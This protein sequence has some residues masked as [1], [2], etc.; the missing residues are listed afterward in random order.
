[1]SSA[2]VNAATISEASGVE[3]PSALCN[4][5]ACRGSS[6]DAVPSAPSARWAHPR[7]S[8]SNDKRTHSGTAAAVSATP[9]DASP[10]G[11]NAQS[12]AARKLSISWA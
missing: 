12:S 5:I 6:V 1:M 2:L 10:L 8:S 7:H 4:R 3:A 9:V 11:E